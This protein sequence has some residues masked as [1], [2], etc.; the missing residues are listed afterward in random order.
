MQA[1]SSRYDF[2]L[3][4][5][6]AKKRHHFLPKAYLKPFCDEEGKLH[7]YRK[8]KPE[9]EIRLS[10]DNTG[11]HKYYYSQ[12]TPSG[13]RDDDTLEDLFSEYES[14][15]PGIVLK[16]RARENVNRHLDTICA[17]IGLQRAR[18][19]AA[20]DACERILAEN[21]KATIRRMRDQGDLPP[22]PFGLGDLFDHVDV[23]IDPHQSIHAMSYS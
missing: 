10:P 19:P 15:W 23:A 12:A 17:F 14:E 6:M 20:R 16:F 2:M 21:V 3:W 4:F 18:V 7:V 13:R 9:Q 8:D 22:L 5:I 11:F 1:W